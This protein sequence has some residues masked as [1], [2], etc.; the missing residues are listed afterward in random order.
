MNQ[1][2]A[3]VLPLGRI[4]RNPQIDPRKGRKKSAYEQLVR[5]ISA[6]GI[7][8]PILVRDAGHGA[9]GGRNSRFRVAVPVG[10]VE[11]GADAAGVAG[12]G[13]PARARDLR[14]VR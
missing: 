4:R 10:R 13:R 1:Q 11:R 14:R 2:V 12:G 6:K 8:Q 3:Q 7:I 9:L 5:S